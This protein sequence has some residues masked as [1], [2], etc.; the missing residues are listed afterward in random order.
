MAGSVLFGAVYASMVD[1][2]A[3]LEG[4]ELSDAEHQQIVVELEDIFQEITAAE[5]QAF[6]STLPSKTREA[7]PKIVNDA[8][9]EGLGAALFAMNVGVAIML[10]L[11]LLLPAIRLSDVAQADERA[12]ESDS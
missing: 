9:E 3:R 2:Y 6:I 4:I 8:A 1:E 5:E 12:A 7:F 10:V 11:S